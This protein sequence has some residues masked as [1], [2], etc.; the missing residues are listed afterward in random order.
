VKPVQCSEWDG[1]EPDQEIA[2]AYGV[3]IF[4]GMNLEKSVR[5]IVFEGG[6]G[7]AFRASIDLVVAATAGQ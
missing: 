6:C 3:P 2:S 7:A 1:G 5:H 4:Q